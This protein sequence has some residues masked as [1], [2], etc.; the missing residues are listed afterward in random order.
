MTRDEINQAY[1][2]DIRDEINQTYFWD[3][4]D[5]INQTYFWEIKGFYDKGAQVNDLLFLLLEVY[6]DGVVD[7][8]G[9]YEGDEW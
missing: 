3:I 1:F 2:W 6:N 9:Y 5:E 7:G 4:R 8:E